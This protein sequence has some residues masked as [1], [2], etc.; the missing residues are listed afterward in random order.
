MDTLEMHVQFH[1]TILL[2]TLNAYISPLSFHYQ[3]WRH[4]AL[5]HEILSI[6]SA[7]PSYSSAAYLQCHTNVDARS[8]RRKRVDKLQ[9]F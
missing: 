6:A 5:Q 3:S 8:Q 7:I 1:K 4:K 2:I 9:W